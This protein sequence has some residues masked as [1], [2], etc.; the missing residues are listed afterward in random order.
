MNLEQ[1]DCGNKISPAFLIKFFN[2]Y[3]CLSAPIGNDRPRTELYINSAVKELFKKYLDEADVANGYITPTKLV[4]IITSEFKAF[5]V[6]EVSYPPILFEGRPRQYIPRPQKFDE[7]QDAITNIYN[8]YVDYK[9]RLVQIDNEILELRAIWI[10][11]GLPS[12]TVDEQKRVLKVYGGDGDPECCICLDDNKD[13]I[14]EPCRHFACCA[15]CSLQVNMCPICRSVILT[16]IP[17][18]IQSDNI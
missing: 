17:H 7:L 9:G 14:F 10:S 6:R 5:N 15:R 13:T 12:F 8:L 1:L 2:T 11:L 18:N 4:K 3:C 16:R